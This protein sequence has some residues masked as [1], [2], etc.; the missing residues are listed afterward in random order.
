MTCLGTSTATVVYTTDRFQTPGPGAYTPPSD[1][2][3]ATQWTIKHKYPD[4]DRKN[5]AGY[6]LLPDEMGAG[7]KHSLSSRHRQRDYDRVPGPSYV[8]P[9]FG[10]AG[11]ASAF[12]QRPEERPERAAPPGPGPGKYQ[13]SAGLEGRRYSMK[14]RQFVHNE[15][16]ADGPGGGKYL[17]DWGR[18]LPCAPMTAVRERYKEFPKPPGPGPGQYPI[19]RSLEHGPAAFH[20]RRREMKPA[21]GPGPGKYDTSRRA[22]SEAPQYSLRSRIDPKTELLRPKYNGLPEA[23]GEGTPRWSMSIRPKDRDWDHVPGPNY[24]PPPFGEDGVKP[25]VREQVKR[26]IGQGNIP[27]GP[28]GGKYNNQPAA[29]GPKWSMKARQFVCNEGGPDGPG[30]GKYLPDY[31]KVQPSDGKG[32]QILERFKERPTEPGAKYVNLGDTNTSPRWT[33]GRHE[34]IGVVPGCR[35]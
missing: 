5:R 31:S 11:P 3:Q 27:F 33:V 24:V 32:R 17:P 25:A 15:G 2:G 18:T 12:H 23:F 34:P 1:F 4:R 14:A 21:H 28:G 20:V 29:G 26:D 13:A 16:G 7:H 22:G 8:P 35:L 30:G 9:R 10:A 6:D 19:D